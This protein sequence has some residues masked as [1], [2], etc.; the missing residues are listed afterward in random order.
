MSVPGP[1]PLQSFLGGIGLA[2][3][4]HV[5][6]YHNSSTFGISGFINGAARGNLEDVLSVLGLISG[7]ILVGAIEGQKPS[8]SVAAPLPLI[9]SGLLVGVGS[10]L[11]N[12]CTSGHMICGLSRF[13]RRSIVATATFFVPA[14]ITA[15]LLHGALVPMPGDSSLGTHGG[16]FLASGFAALVSTLAASRVMSAG[17]RMRQVIAFSSA[18]AFALGLRL[19]NLSDPRRVLGFLV[20]PAHAAFDTSLV[21]LAVGA[22]PLASVL[23]RLG[24]VRLEGKTTIDAHLLA[25][26]IMFG[27]GWGITGLCPGPGLINFGRAVA[28]SADI[29]PIATWLAAVITGGFLVPS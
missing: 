11:A 9:L 7:G 8:L 3:P 29:T 5:L 13:S 23:Y 28:T 10:K 18:M 27:L 14:S 1:T 24:S 4:A 26:S 15:S 2:L 6:L 22:V 16:A 25:G 20:T 17:P 12:G 19:S 21:Y